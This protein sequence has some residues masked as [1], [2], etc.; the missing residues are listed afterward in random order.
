LPGG[1]PG[2][3]GLCRRW[4][5]GPRQVIYTFGDASGRRAH[6][7]VRHAGNDRVA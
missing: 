2:I 3:I 1:S 5:A 4:T 7:I 6:Q